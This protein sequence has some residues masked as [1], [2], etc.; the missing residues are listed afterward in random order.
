MATR[1]SVGVDTPQRRA[2]RA[3]ADAVRRARYAKRL[4]E[5]LQG[6]KTIGEV[7]RAAYLA[8]HH[9]CYARWLYRV[10]RG[11]VVIVRERPMRDWADG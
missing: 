5:R 8:G 4:R 7:W 11:D 3:K 10:R 9:A 2:A 1:P 6:M